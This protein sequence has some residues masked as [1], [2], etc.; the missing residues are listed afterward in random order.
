MI[1]NFNSNKARG[2][3][4]VETVVALFVFSIGALGIAALQLTTLV[5]SDDVKQRSVAIWKA[6]EL[7]ERVRATKAA[8]GPNGIS[9][10]TRD[11]IPLKYIAALGSDDISVIGSVANS[12]YSCPAVAVTRCDDTSTADAAICS[13][14]ELI[15]FDIWS[16]LC[17]PISGAS[18]ETNV[19]DEEGINKLKNLDVVLLQSG[20]EMRL[21]FEW[22]ARAGDL[23]EDLKDADGDGRLVATDLCEDEVD[24]DSTLSTYCLRFL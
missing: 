15:A 3:T 1:V 13:V 18:Y 10:L 6:Q 7:A 11:E 21:Y 23:N 17:D 24:V 16:V 9:G 5:R 2:A 19:S 12:G 8:F 22:Q 4:L 14:D 20:L